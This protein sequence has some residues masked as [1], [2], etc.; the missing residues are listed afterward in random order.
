V[1]CTA[2]APLQAG[3]ASLEGLVRQLDGRAAAGH[4]I[5]LIDTD[6]RDLAQSAVGEDGRYSFAD[7]G[8]GE[9]ALGVELPGGGLAPVLA[10]PVRLAED[11]LARR[12]LKLVAA[13]AESTGT[14]LE[15]NSGLRQWFG[16]ISKPAKVWTIAGVIL[17]GVLIYDLIDD[18]PVATQTEPPEGA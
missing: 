6:G 18:E 8:A 5:H 15:S 9:Y 16:E 2:G 1:F 12:D 14:A 4:R 3:G 11:Q 13:D 7:L 17:A 10:P